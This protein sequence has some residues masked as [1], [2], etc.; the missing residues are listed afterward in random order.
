[1]KGTP[2]RFGPRFGVIPYLG[3]FVSRPAPAKALGVSVTPLKQLGTPIPLQESVTLL[4]CCGCRNVPC[5]SRKYVMRA[6]F[7]VLLLMVQVCERLICCTRA[8]LL[9]PNPSSK[10]GV[11]AWNLVK[12]CESTV[13]LKK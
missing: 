5:A 9:F 4:V 10:L 7:T 3:L 12:G 6:S 2:S 8:A 13:S 11:G 1:M